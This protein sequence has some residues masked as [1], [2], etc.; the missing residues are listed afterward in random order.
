MRL[1]REFGI[2][3]VTVELAYDDGQPLLYLATN[4]Y[5]G[6][7]LRDGDVT[8]LKA[9]LKVEGLYYMGVKIDETTN[10]VTRLEDK[11]TATGQVIYEQELEVYS[12]RK[13]VAHT[14]IDN[15]SIR[16]VGVSPTG[17]CVL[18]NIAVVSQEGL[19]FLVFQTMANDLAFREGDGVSI[20]GFQ[21]TPKWVCLGQFL[22]DLLSDPEVLSQL[23]L[24]D[25]TE[26]R[27][28]PAVSFVDGRVKWYS[29]R[30]QRGAIQTP[31][32]DA[33]VR[34]GTVPKRDDGLRY[35]VPGEVVSDYSLRSIASQGKGRP[36]GFQWQVT[37]LALP[38]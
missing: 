34:W 24:K 6:D 29:L 14:R 1:K 26:Y 22:E 30:Q 38:E 35:L 25:V 13:G 23:T 10:L 4:G 3:G 27:P 37:S 18:W 16:I 12:D 5:I 2:P 11:S 32:G 9:T 33:V 21:V 19:F 15:N 8:R 7:H 28:A 36:T 31:K 17:E 20:P